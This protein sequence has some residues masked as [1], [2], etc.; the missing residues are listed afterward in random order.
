MSH[1]HCDLPATAIMELH[2]ATQADLGCRQACL[3]IDGIFVGFCTGQA[4]CA[5]GQAV[6]CPLYHTDVD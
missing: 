5:D 4:V 6:R 2:L 3:C 1:A